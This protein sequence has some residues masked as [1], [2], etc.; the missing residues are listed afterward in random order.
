M[1]AYPQVDT[2]TLDHLRRL[3]A[4]TDELARA[5]GRGQPALRDSAGNI[6]ALDPASSTPLLAAQ[7]HDVAV[8]MRDST[9]H[10]TSEDGQTPKNLNAQLI[11]CDAIGP[12]PDSGITMKVYGEIGDPG[13]Q[14]NMWGTLRGNAGQPGEGY[15]YYGDLIGNSYGTHNGAVNPQVQGPT[16]PV[17]PPGPVGPKGFV[18]DHPTDPERWLVHACT[19][20]PHNGI[21]YWGTTLV[22]D[23][24]GRVTLPVYFEDIAQ[25][26]GRT[27]H[28]TPMLT[29]EKTLPK[30]LTI[31]ASY[32][33]DGQFGIVASKDVTFEVSWLVHAIRCDVPALLV[34]PKRSEVRVSGMGPYRTYEVIGDQQVPDAVESPPQLVRMLWTTVGTEQ[35]RVDALVQRLVTLERRLHEM[36]TGETGA[37]A[38]T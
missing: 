38:T 28:L 5:L 12:R 23:G 37:R 24:V 20:A 2:S 32:P 10:V 21:E 31:Y 6:L 11:A 25:T 7:G 14:W 29:H 36:E 13:Q 19:E 22:E 4:T 35:V 18:I 3:S 30:S 33:I 1:V 27:V 8:N 34:E 9:L 16:G 17:G 26:W 15:Q